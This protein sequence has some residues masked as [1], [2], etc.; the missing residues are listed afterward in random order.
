MTDLARP[1]IKDFLVKD[2]T[3]MDPDFFNRRFGLIVKLLTTYADEIEQ[4]SEVADQIYQVGLTRITDL[5]GPF[6]EKID[7]ASNLGFLVATSTTPL[8]LSEGLDVV[9]QIDED[10]RD[11]FYPTPFLTATRSA[12]DAADQFATLRLT[13]YD[14]ESGALSVSVTSVSGGVEADEHNDWVIADGSGLVQAITDALAAAITAQGA[15][16]ADRAAVSGDRSAVATDKATT[17]AD[18]LSAQSYKDAAQ[19]AAADILTALDAYAPLA[20]PAL[21]GNPTAPTQAPGNNS[22]RIAT[23]AF[24]TALA[25]FLAPLASPAFTGNPTAPTQLTADSSTKLATTAFAHAVADAAAAALVNASPSTLDTLKELADAL[26]DDPNFAATITTALGLKAP[27]ASP[28]LTGNPTA[29]TQAPGDDST[30]LATTAFVTAACAAIISGAGYAPLASPAFTG[31]PTAPTASS[32]TNTTQLATTAFVQTL[33]AALTKA[34]VGLANVDNTADTAKPVSTAQQAALDT[35]APLA[36]PALTGTPTAPTASS[37]TNTTQL[38]TTAYV[39][40][41]ILARI[42]SADVLSFKGVIDCSANP[43]YPAADA[44]AMYK[45]SVAG[46][47]GGASGKSVEVGDTIICCVDSTA[48]GNDATVGANWSILQTNIS[49][50]SS[51][52]QSLFSATTL[53]AYLTALGISANARAIIEAADYA[54]IRTALSLVIGTNVLAYSAKVQTIADLVLTGQSGKVLAVKSNETDFEL[55]AAAAGMVSL[56][57]LDMSSGSSVDLTGIPSG[58]RELYIEIEGISSSSAASLKLALS[59]T[60]GAAWGTSQTIS[61]ALSSAAAGFSGVIR[62]SNIATTI[63]G[64][65]AVLSVLEETGSTAVT[66]KICSTNTAAIVNALRFTWSAGNFDGGSGLG[67]V[68]GVK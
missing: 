22:T 26:G 7:A 43:N 37:G 14:K 24:V 61:Q 1:S 25:A 38:A 50:V 21:T 55:I 63:A 46:K 30:K 53:D 36:S 41:E 39:I 32:A 68:W 60:N 64:G 62:I 67:R 2:G 56:G 48:A 15:T 28:A 45:I 18:M 20:S 4:T 8:T 27:L 52:V 10:V 6:L 57:S 33:I 5:L 29:P 58:Y 44:G 51:F 66:G 35:K 13:T 65:K 54:A 11:L 16:A 12:P 17:H 40:A 34:S 47:I 23:T 19:G 59:S 42:A 9:F 31:V 49:A 3:D